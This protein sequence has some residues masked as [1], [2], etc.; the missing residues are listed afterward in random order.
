[1]IRPGESSVTQL[2]VE[3]FVARVFPLVPGQLVRPG[4]PPPAVLPL[5]DV[6]LL[7][8]VGPQVG[9]EVAGLGVRLAAARVVAG[10]GGALPLEDD[11]DLGRVW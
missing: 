3:R 1:M 7:P 10:V 4:K 6:G 2:T 11:H 8:C 5:A 9:L